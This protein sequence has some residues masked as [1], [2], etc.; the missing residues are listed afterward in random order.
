M[1]KQ[2]NPESPE[3]IILLS[4]EIVLIII[5][6]ILFLISTIIFILG[7]LPQK[8]KFSLDNLTK[9]REILDDITTTRKK[10]ILIGVSFFVLSVIIS[11]ATVF[12][13]LF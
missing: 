1:V 7:L 6:A 3:G 2:I 5:P 13:N 12:L 4:L 9:T 8:V 11:C 10:V